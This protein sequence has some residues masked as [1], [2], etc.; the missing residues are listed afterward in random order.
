[1]D[2]QKN[3]LPTDWVL[4]THHSVQLA[5][6]AEVRVDHSYQAFTTRYLAIADYRA[7]QADV[8]GLERLIQNVLQRDRVL[9][10]KRPEGVNAWLGRMRERLDGPGR[11][12]L[13]RARYG[14]REPV[15]TAYRTAIQQ[16]FDLL[17]Q[18]TPS[19]ESIKSL[20]GSS[21]AALDGIERT[22]AKIVALA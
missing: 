14:M 20:A 8:M 15:L 21:A 19:L 5:I 17:T 18:I 4:S 13:G 1:L 11:L 3:T 2:E 6:D 16:P 12:Q 10:A 9:G 22:S 7:K